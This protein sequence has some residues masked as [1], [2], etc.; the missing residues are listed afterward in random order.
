[1]G[2]YCWLIQQKSVFLIKCLFIYFGYTGS[3]LWH[4]G[5]LVVAYELLVAECGVQFPDQGSNPGHLHWEQGITGE[6]PTVS[7]KGPV[8]SSESLNQASVSIPPVTLAP[9]PLD[10]NIAH[11]TQTPILFP[12]SPSSPSFPSS[13]IPTYTHLPNP[14]E[15]NSQIITNTIFIQ[16]DNLAVSQHALLMSDVWRMQ[17]CH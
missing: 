15:H 14:S 3:W 1:M 17:D 6:V 5:S 7:L 16:T 11:Y 4:T 10:R 9:F 13:P 12:L 2:I 8:L